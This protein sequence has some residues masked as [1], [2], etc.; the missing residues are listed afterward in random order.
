[1]RIL[2]NVLP[3]CSGTME[4]RVVQVGGFKTGELGS[5]IQ[6]PAD[7]DTGPFGGADRHNA[8][9]HCLCMGSWFRQHQFRVRAELGVGCASVSM[10]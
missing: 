2:C 8:A 7:I 4:R 3:F 1:M 6:A 5:P 9:F 10:C